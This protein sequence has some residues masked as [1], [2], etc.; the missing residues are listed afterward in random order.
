MPDASGTWLWRL[1][2]TDWARALCLSPWTD[3]HA[4]VLPVGDVVHVLLFRGQ[5]SGL[6][7]LQH[8]AEHETYGR[9]PDAPE[10]TPLV[11]P[12]KAET[13][14]LVGDAR[15]RLWVGADSAT[16]VQIR[17]SDPPY[18]RW[19]EALTLAADIAPDDICA[20]VPLAHRNVGV[21][22]SN[23]TTRQFGFRVHR[24]GDAPADWSADERPA[25][26]SGLDVGLGMADDHLNVA[27]SANGTLYAAVKTS[28][29]SAGYPLVALLVRRPD[30]TWDPLYSVD[31]EGSRPIVIISRSAQQLVVVVYSSY[32]DRRIVCRYSA[33]EQIGFGRRFDLIVHPGI[34]NAT[35]TPQ[36][37]SVPPVILATARDSSG[38]RAYG[39]QLA[40]P[41]RTAP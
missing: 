18:A 28:Y 22:W 41:P 38:Y 34:N 31:D 27:L 12:A 26:A 6:L 35:S 4:D 21:L 16:E 24:A 23:Q 19:G 20:M 40:R 30:G 32:R 15:G 10:L 2:G 29:D 14:T 39:V 9:W 3:T 1:Q 33:L 8:R 37:L 17:W 11:L 5:Q 7:S 25:A 13:A 36:R